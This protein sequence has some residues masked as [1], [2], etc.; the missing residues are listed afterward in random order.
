MSID[1]G[2]IE[3]EVIKANSFLG[4]GP[5]KYIIPAALCSFRLHIKEQF[6]LLML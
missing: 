6:F 3:Q 2:T 4:F 5:Q 1:F